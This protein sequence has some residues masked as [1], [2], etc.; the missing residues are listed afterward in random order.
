MM[1]FGTWQKKNMKVGIFQDREVPL[2]DLF[3]HSRT[4]FA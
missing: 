1:G 3:H 4:L 2:N